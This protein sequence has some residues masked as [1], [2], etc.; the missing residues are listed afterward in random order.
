MARYG[1][2]EDVLKEGGRRSSV[3]WREITRVGDGGLED[4]GL[5]IVFLKLWGMGGIRYF[6]L[7]CGLMGWCCH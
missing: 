3:W 4:S 1:E 2:E 5:G 7:A 6:G